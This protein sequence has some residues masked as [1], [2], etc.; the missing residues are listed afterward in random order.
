MI[1]FLLHVTKSILSDIFYQAHNSSGGCRY[2]QAD[3]LGEGRL[4][5]WPRIF[6]LHWLSVSN[7]Y[8]SM[9]NVQYHLVLSESQ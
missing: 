8:F 2:E 4:P 9:F 1:S 6:N 5:Y 3:I 7:I